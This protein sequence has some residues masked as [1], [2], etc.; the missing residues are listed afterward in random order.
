MSQITIGQVTFRL[1]SETRQDSW[2]ARAESN[3]TGERFG[4]ECS[5]STQAEVIER[6][7]AWLEWQREHVV[8]LDKLQQAEHAYHRAVVGGAFVGTTE[9]SSVFEARKALLELVDEARA[10]LDEV[11]ARKPA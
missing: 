11:R 2:I 7:H 9:G 1:V 6:L 3:E 4:I 5:G 8:A 10:T